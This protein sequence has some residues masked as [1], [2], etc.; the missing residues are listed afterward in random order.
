MSL[1][2]RHRLLEETMK[3]PSKPAKVA[4]SPMLA[5]AGSTILL[6][7]GLLYITN[8]DAQQQ[9]EIVTEQRDAT[10]ERAQTLADQIRAACDT[11]ELTGPACLT[12]EEVAAEPI[13]GPQ[14]EPGTPGEIGPR[15]PQ[16]PM[17]PVGL[18]GDTGPIGPAGPQGDTGP[19]GPQGIEGDD[20]TSITGDQGPA[21]PAGPAGTEGPAGDQ[22][23]QGEPPSS[24][25]WTD[26]FGVVYT[27]VRD[28]GSSDSEPTYTCTSS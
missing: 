25:R 27:C 2:A 26:S 12:A 16:G 21:G 7:V 3:Q 11:G 14:G 28:E 23:P 10:A 17:G 19:Q 6:V 4:F 24:W 1:H 9:T 18:K 8:T 5:L 22:G 20:G 15:G 13:V